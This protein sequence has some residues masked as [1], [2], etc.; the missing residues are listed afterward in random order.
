MRERYRAA[1]LDVASFHRHYRA[2]ALAECV[3]VCCHG[4][5]GFYLEEEPETIRGLV[6]RDPDFFAKHGLAVPDSLFAEKTNPR[7]GATELNT[8]KR[9][10]IYPDGLLAA[11]FP[12][13]SCVFRR[14]DGACTLQLQGLEEGRPGWWYKPL[15]CWLFPIELECAGEPCIRV[16][17]ASTDEYVDVDYPGF[18]GFIRCGAE[19]QSGGEPAYKVV[20]AELAA[21]SKL[22]DRDLLSEILA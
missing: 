2:C 4:G 15:A 3:G 11:H 16:A 9:D 13:T 18:T 21:L 1:P 20:A 19:W 7:T 14:D 6:R 22:L 5:V 12:S 10:C 8:G 17:H